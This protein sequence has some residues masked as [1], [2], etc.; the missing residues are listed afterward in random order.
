[1]NYTHLRHYHTDCEPF[2]HPL[3]DGCGSLDAD[4]LDQMA[5]HVLVG[6]SPDD[7]ILA[8]RGCVSLLV[9]RYIANWP[10]T[11]PYIDDMVS[12]GMS[13]I[14]RLCSEIPL[15]LFRERGI[16]VI[17]TS[18]AQYGIENM[19]NKMRSVTAPSSASQRRL[20]QRDEEPIYAVAETREY[21]EANHPLDGGDEGCRDILDAFCRLEPKDEIDEFLLDES[22]WGKTH[23]ELG[24][25]IGIS[26]VAV[27]A[28]R[29]KLYQ[30]YLELTE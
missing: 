3:L 7:L 23:A 29:Q 30:R 18:R 20:I 17:A 26:K 12:E 8:L 1:M 21:D 14:S 24:R 15:D 4:A 28:R 10:D 2:D 9:G 6:D 16:L 13:E 27:M 22:N 11:R 19:L 5:E 25:A